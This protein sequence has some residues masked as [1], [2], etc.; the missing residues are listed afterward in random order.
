MY[1][2]YHP[3]GLTCQILT[4]QNTGKWQ[5]AFFWSSE[6]GFS[7]PSSLTRALQT[8]RLSRTPTLPGRMRR[9][10][11]HQWNAVFQAH[12]CVCNLYWLAVVSP[13]FPKVFQCFHHVSTTSS[14]IF[15]LHSLLHN[16]LQPPQF[17]HQ[18]SRSL[19]IHLTWRSPSRWS[20]NSGVLQLSLP[21]PRLTR[22]YEALLH[23]QKHF[24][25]K[26]LEAPHSR[27]WMAISSN[28]EWIGVGNH[29]DH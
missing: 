24:F 18:A 21:K 22:P 12:T 1:H 26:Y 29:H 16:L 13:Y 2:L 7:D 9:E 10:H 17:D 11:G 5:V 4:I 27:F 6:T 28:T 8:L 3:L 19:G 23:Q 20:F 25:C 15:T 14:P